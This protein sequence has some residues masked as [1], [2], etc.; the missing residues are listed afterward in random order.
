MFMY[1]KMNLKI[2]DVKL[3]FGQ[4]LSVLLGKGYICFCC[5]LHRH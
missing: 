5:K 4:Y 2:S 3:M 1:V